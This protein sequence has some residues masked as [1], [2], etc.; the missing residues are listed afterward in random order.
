MLTSRNQFGR[1]WSSKSS[2]SIRG[3][4]FCE[5]LNTSDV[6]SV[7]F[8]DSRAILF[9]AD[10]HILPLL[11]LA[12][13]LG[14]FHPTAAVGVCQMGRLQQVIWSNCC[15]V[16]METYS[17]WRDCLPWC[18]FDHEPIYCWRVD[19]SAVTCCDM[20]QKYEIARS[21]MGTLCTKP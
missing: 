20:L 16:L 6:S 11:I 13:S 5:C 4:H 8:Q 10:H 21:L 9:C 3:L 14:K 19:G 18:L 12:T 1:S 17:K 15:S 7:G 2:S